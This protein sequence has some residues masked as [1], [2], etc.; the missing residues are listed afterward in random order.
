MWID[1]HCHIDKLKE[2]PENVINLAKKKGVLCLLT[3]GT[4]LKDWN[5]V[6]SLS[7][8]HSP[9]VYGT[10]GMHPHKAQSFDD[11]CDTFLR[12][13]LPS[14]RIVGVGEIGLD[15]F[16]ENSSSDIQKEVFE[17]QLN[18]AEEFHLPVEIHTRS[19]ESDT[20]YFLKK[21]QSKVQGLLHCFT[22][23]YDLAKQALDC[24]FNI[25]FSGILTFKKAESLRKTCKKIPLDRIHIETDSPFLC[26]E[27]HRGKENNP[28]YIPFI[29]QL[30][31][32]LH[33][34]DLETLSQQLKENTYKLFPKIK[35]EDF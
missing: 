28:S 9:Y 15:Y 21:Y 12:K 1:T 22:G 35:K 24:G 4:E 33:K 23:S 2:S 13:H 29:A 27:P 11:S 32:K 3:I 34:I 19:A 30:V 26:P 14:Q 16:Y 10:L 5:Q 17:K 20:L 7:K 25:S 6:L 18:L 8:K 31:A